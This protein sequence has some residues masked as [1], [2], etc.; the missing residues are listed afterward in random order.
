MT[1]LVAITRLVAHNAHNALTRLV[2]HITVS[3][4]IFQRVDAYF[5]R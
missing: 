2:A 5:S 4:M 1:R 3:I